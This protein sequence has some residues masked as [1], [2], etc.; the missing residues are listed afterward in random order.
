MPHNCQKIF[1][2]LIRN[3]T[4]Y[5]NMS[6]LPYNFYI[7]SPCWVIIH[8]S[9]YRGPWH[10]QRLSL[11]WC[12]HEHLE[13]STGHFPRKHEYGPSFDSFNSSFL[14][15]IPHL[16]NSLFW[17]NIRP[18]WRI[19][20]SSNTQPLKHFLLYTINRKTGSFLSSQISGVKL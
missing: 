1:R 10:R 15:T 14:D 4:W 11:H 16:Q 13:K 6:L 19:C 7:V 3:K 8:H 12:Q 9:G 17:W 18:W 20:L 5:K 2:N